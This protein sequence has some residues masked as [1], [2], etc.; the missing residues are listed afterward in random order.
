MP[1]IRHNAHRNS[2]PRSNVF[3]RGC[4]EIQLALLRLLTVLKC[5]LRQRHLRTMRYSSSLMKDAHPSVFTFRRRSIATEVQPLY[6]ACIHT[7]TTPATPYSPH[8]SSE[9]H[10]EQFQHITHSLTTQQQKPDAS[11]HSNNHRSRS[12]HLY[13]DGNL[14]CN[15]TFNITQRVINCHRYSSDYWKKNEHRAKNSV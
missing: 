8:T 14:H 3:I 12:Q 4:C 2:Q 1:S 11:I 13:R 7:L 15:P 9:N 6:S 10:H 5:C